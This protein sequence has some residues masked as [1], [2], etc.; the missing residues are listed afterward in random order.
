MI[1]D[2]KLPEFGEK[3]VYSLKDVQWLPNRI[4][5]LKRKETN[6]LRHIVDTGGKN[7]YIYYITTI[8]SG[9][10]IPMF[11]DS[12]PFSSHSRSYIKGMKYQQFNP[13]NWQVHFRVYRILSP[14]FQCFPL[15][16]INAQ[17]L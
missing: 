6:E 12:L 13:A 9:T 10:I 2:K 7:H 11:K 16:R 3:H 14:L 15:T 17:E 4:R 1:K 5:F 8:Y